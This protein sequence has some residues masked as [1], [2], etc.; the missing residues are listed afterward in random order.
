[1]RQWYYAKN[2]ERTGPIT[3]D[4]IAEL[5]GSGAITGDTLVW[6]TELGG[7]TRAGEVEA[8]IPK[9]MPKILPFVSYDQV[10][11]YRK[12][13]FAITCWFVCPW[14]V[15][16]L[17]FCGGIYYQ[18]DGQLRM[19]SMVAKVVLAVWCALQVVAGFLTRP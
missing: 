1:M 2:R 18:K 11:W 13:W 12:N 7:W 4:E 5:L 19:Y 10:P 8:L 16:V 17:A 6:T 9:N 3:D 15:L 14:I